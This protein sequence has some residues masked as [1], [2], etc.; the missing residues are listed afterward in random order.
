MFHTPTIELVNLQARA[1]EI[2]LVMCKTK[3]EKEMELTDLKKALLQAKQ[4]Y[5]IEGIVTGALFST[6]Q[7]D[8]I[9]KVC[10]EVG[11]KIFSP[12]WH[13]PQELE[14]H[15]LLDGGFEFIFTGIAADGLDKSWLNRVINWDDLEKLKKLREKQGMN[16]AGEGG[17][18]ES[19]VLDCPLFKKKLVI[20]EAEIKE[21]SKNVARLLVKKAKLVDK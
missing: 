9:E 17:E 4:K 12:L 19:L 15:E 18:F 6:Y 1:M 5:K 16:V 11:L 8:R 7:R 21:E 13:K 3:G 14:M 20:E 2:P 10:D